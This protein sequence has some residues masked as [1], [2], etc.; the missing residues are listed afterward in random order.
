MSSNLK[1]ALIGLAVI[2]VVFIVLLFIVHNRTSNT[3]DPHLRD[4]AERLVPKLQRSSGKWASAR[5]VLKRYEYFASQEQIILEHSKNLIPSGQFVQIQLVPPHGTA[6][7]LV[8]SS[9]A[10]APMNVDATS[11]LLTAATKQPR[12]VSVQ[13]AGTTYQ[14]YLAPLPIPGVL[15]RDNV[16]GVIEV[17]ES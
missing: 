14:V 15:R 11:L 13:Q 2:A 10:G 12:Y 16:T 4:T 7:A 6:S 3:Q 5:T 8:L 9:R 17:A 1:T